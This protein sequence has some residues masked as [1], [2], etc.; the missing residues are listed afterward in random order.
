MRL[1]FEVTACDGNHGVRTTHG[2]LRHG[3]FSCPCLNKQRRYNPFVIVRIQTENNRKAKEKNVYK[4]KQLML[5][6][7]CAGWK[8]W[9]SG[10]ASNVRGAWILLDWIWIDS[11]TLRLYGTRSLLQLLQP[12]LRPRWRRL[13]IFNFD[14]YRF[15]LWFRLWASFFIR[16]F[17]I[18]MP[19][20]WGSIFLWLNPLT[21]TQWVH[22]I[23][24][25]KAVCSGPPILCTHPICKF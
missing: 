5:S 12:L 20:L 16:E 21:P 1:R 4:Q 17:T 8:S 24:S 15:R 9:G 22:A 6:T 25:S 10:E 19:L 11:W 18:G 23:W 14:Q 3:S 2:T 13:V 7:C